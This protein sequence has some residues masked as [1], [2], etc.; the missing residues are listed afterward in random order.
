MIQAVLLSQ[1]SYILIY[2]AY[3]PQPFHTPCRALDISWQ[4]QLKCESEPLLQESLITSCCWFGG[5]CREIWKGGCEYQ[6][7]LRGGY[8][9]S[10]Q[11]MSARKIEVIKDTKCRTSQH[12][13]PGGLS[14]LLSCLFL[15]C[16][17]H[18][19]HPHMD[20]NHTISSFNL[21]SSPD[22]TFWSLQESL[23]RLWISN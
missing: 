13:Q 16:T 1:N 21:I 17:S 11:E 18:L 12:S 7:E 10:F 22:G 19:G 8:N 20:L 3:F 9:R 2:R 5:E 4:K 14:E 15:L 6:S 23:H